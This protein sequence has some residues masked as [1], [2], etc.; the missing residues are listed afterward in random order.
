[1]PVV[2]LARGG[3]HNYGAE[4]MLRASLE[5][6]RAR[7]PELVAV[8]HPD[9]A[10]P[11]QRGE[12][13]VKTM[14]PGAARGGLSKQIT[15]PLATALLGKSLK[16][17]DMVRVRDLDG[18]VD[19]GGFSL[20]DQWGASPAARIAA[21][22]F[23]FSRRKRP[24]VFLP[25][26]FG[27]FQVRAVREFARRSIGN[28]ALV[29]ARDRQSVE[30]ID[31][32]DTGRECRLCPDITFNYA[33]EPDEQARDVVYFVPNARVVDRGGASTS[34]YLDGMVEAAQTIRAQGLRPE[35]MVHA[36]GAADKHLAVE[37]AKALGQAPQDVV[38]PA[39]GVEAK[40]LL[41]GS[42][43]VIGSRYHA[44]LGALSGGV[45][46]LAVGWSHKYE[47]VLVDLDQP[48]SLAVRVDESF[49][50]RMADA[51]ELLLNE[52]DALAAKCEAMLPGIKR[53]VSSMWDDV[54]TCLAAGATR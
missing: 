24:F 23:S 36:P 48:S 26:A 54:A 47:E 1:M 4:L 15:G 11:E 41:S 30:M 28:A 45:P 7:L 12:L 19:M 2:E 21:H 53:Q 13:G 33:V 5:A 6:L 39:T 22:T 25:Q 10:G 3:F 32:L 16:R 29:Y 40:A 8:V 27:P 18:C 46:V 37:L 38:I 9:V 20:T 52:R 14:P 50:E 34:A 42:R 49:A 43:A 44:L 31:Q 51:V 17:Y 35:V